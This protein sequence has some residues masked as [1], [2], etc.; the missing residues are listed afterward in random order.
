[1]LESRPAPSLRAVCL[2][3]AVAAPL[4]ALVEAGQLAA[5]AVAPH[6]SETALLD[7]LTL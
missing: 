3:P 1:M 6:P 4:E 7:L 5:V 2:S